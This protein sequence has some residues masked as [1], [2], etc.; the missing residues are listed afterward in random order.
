MAVSN[1]A[2][3]RKPQ[4]IQWDTDERYELARPLEGHIRRT[5]MNL[6][7]GLL[8]KMQE[9]WGGVPTHVKTATNIKTGEVIVGKA[10]ADDEFVRPVRRSR[11]ESYFSFARPLAM[12]EVEVPGDIQL[13]VPAFTREVPNAGTVFVFAMFKRKAVPR[14]SK[15]AAAGQPAPATP[16]PGA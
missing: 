15:K 13:N 4:T 11:T 3:G 9:V 14:R 6:T 1:G 2:R 12:L 7:A 16:S 5:R 10:T 8:A